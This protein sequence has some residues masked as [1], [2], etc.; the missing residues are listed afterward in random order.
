[1]VL[2]DGQI[3]S[4]FGSGTGKLEQWIEADGTPQQ[5]AMRFRI[6]GAAAAG[7]SEIAIAEQLSVNRNT[8]I[9]WRK[10]RRRGI[11]RSLEHC[12]K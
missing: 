1:M 9:L 5:V 7:N 11:G 3:L 12:A 6:V 4:A 10:F 2:G 8:V